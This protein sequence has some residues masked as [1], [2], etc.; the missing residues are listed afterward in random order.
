MSIAVLGRDVIRELRAHG[1]GADTQLTDL[2]VTIDDVLEQCSRAGALLL[3]PL[4]KHLALLVGEIRTEIWRQ[5]AAALLVLAQR[6]DDPLVGLLRLL[7]QRLVSVDRSARLCTASAGALPTSGS[8]TG[9]GAGA[10]GGGSA[11]RQPVDARTAH[12]TSPQARRVSLEAARRLC[13]VY[14]AFLDL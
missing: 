3:N 6:V 12:V 13:S 10:G 8:G 1:R 14:M 9:T 4:G 5:L 2:L 11:L 7:L